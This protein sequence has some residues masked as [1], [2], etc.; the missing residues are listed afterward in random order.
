[1]T[2]AASRLF[3]LPPAGGSAGVFRGWDDRLGELLGD[4]LSVV[5]PELPGRGA[6]IAERPPPEVDGY[7]RDLDQRYAPAPGERWAVVGH[8]FGALL[9]ASWAAVAHQSGRGPALVV[10]SGAAAPWRHSTAALLDGSDDEI[11]DRVGALGGLPAQIRATPLGRRLV[12][13]ALVGD[14]RASARYRPAGPAPVGCPVLAVRGADDPLVSDELTTAWSALTT[15]AFTFRVLP[16]GH[17]Y[18]SG[19]ED[20]VP[21]LADVLSAPT[22]PATAERR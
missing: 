6:R 14:V 22:L 8:S 17:F 16:G 18:R 11:W 15:A 5:A 21:L 19:M 13:R 9:A 2:V 1:M 20:L 12:E 10:V 7:V 4:A 3:L